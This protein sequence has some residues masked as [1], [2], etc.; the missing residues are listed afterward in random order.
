MVGHIA[1]SQCTALLLT[2]LACPEIWRILT[3]WAPIVYCSF[4]GLHAAFAHGLPLQDLPKVEVERVVLLIH[5]A[6]EYV[7]VHRVQALRESLL[8]LELG[9][10]VFQEV[11]V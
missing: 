11:H 5:L 4:V 7:L 10:Q 2:G 8:L 3:L 9:S 6:I 1:L